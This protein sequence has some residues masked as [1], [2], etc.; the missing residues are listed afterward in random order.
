MKTL[1]ISDIKLKNPLILAGDLNTTGTDVSPT[2]VKKEVLKKV[3]DPEF[4]AKQAI[5]SL[6]PVT[7]VQNVV[8]GTVNKVRQFKDP[9]IRHIPIV[10]PNKER[11][12]FD[13]IK[14]FRFNDGNAF[15]IRSTSE[16]SSNVGH[17]LFSNSNERELKGFKATFELERHFGIAKYK[18]DWIFVKPSNLKNPNDKNSSYTYAPHFG[19]TLNL[20]NRSFG[21]ISDHD[22]IIVDIPVSEPKN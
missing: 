14:E 8:L 10:F 3:K 19:R 15:D 16:R 7:F 13:L 2:S 12:I 9:T 22:P 4:I 17:G 1:S 5:L 11:E 6:T 20:I 18:L 21:K